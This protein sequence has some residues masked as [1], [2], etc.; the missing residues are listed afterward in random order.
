VLG[1][2]E[3]WSG[4]QWNARPD[5]VEGAVKL[6]PGTEGWRAVPAADL[7]RRL[8]VYRARALDGTQVPLRLQ[9][10]WHAKEGNRFLS[11][12][13]RVVYPRETW[14]SFETLLNAPPGADIGYVYATLHDGA[15]GVVEVKSVELK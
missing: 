8:L 12:M 13:I 14:H 4:W 5:Q 3:T 6:R 11:T 7:D 10:N 15:Q 9:V 1:S 2:R